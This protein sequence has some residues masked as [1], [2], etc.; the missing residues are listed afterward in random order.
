MYPPPQGFTLAVAVISSIIAL[1]WGPPY[2]ALCRIGGDGCRHAQYGL[3]LMGAAALQP[4]N[5]Y[6]RPGK[7]GPGRRS[8]ERL[9]K[10]VRATSRYGR[11]GEGG[12]R[13]CRAQGLRK[14]APGGEL[15]RAVTTWSQGGSVRLFC[16]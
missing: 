6:F 14:A 15:R 8:W 13:R 2:A 7:G 3:L 11:E 16:L 4:I 10:M 9:H 12:P 5:A 1:T